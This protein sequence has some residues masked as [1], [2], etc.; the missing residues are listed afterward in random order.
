MVTATLRIRKCHLTDWCA[1]NKEEDLIT[2]TLD[3][4]Y[5]SWERA[6]FKAPQTPRSPADN[7]KEEE[8]ND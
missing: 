2:C 3:D 5:T 8:N 6:H 4:V 1:T 7:N